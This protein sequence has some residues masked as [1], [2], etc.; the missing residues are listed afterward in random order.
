MKNRK[1]FFIECSEASR[2]CD[3]AQYDEASRFDKFKIHLHNF[4]C[5]P[6]SDY[7]EKNVKLTK[8]IKKAEIKTCSEAEKQS[9]R[10]K[11][12]QETAK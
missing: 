1:I 6:C 9:W 7:T 8:I 2:C 3:K 11:I 10:D 5:R 4:F 12:T